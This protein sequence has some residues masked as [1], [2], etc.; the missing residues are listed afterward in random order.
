MEESG[1]AKRPSFVDKVGKLCY[2]GKDVAAY[3]Y[4][5]P[6]DEGQRQRLRGILDAILEAT[7]KSSRR[8]LPAIVK[9]LKGVLDAPPSIGGAEQLQDGFDRLVKLWQAARSGL[10]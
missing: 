6:D 8:E 10:F 5:V 7:A 4:Q 1:R 9:D 2:E 3:L